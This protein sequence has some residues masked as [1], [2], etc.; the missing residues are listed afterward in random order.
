MKI[1]NGFVSNSSSSSFIIM[2]EGETSTVRDVAKIMINK[3]IE[4][5]KIGWGDWKVNVEY[6]NE[7]LKNL[8]TVDENCSVEFPSTNY[9]TWIKKI[10]DR[11]LISTCNNK[12]WDLPNQTVMSDELKEELKNIISDEDDLENFFDS[13]EFY[14]NVLFK[15]FY[16]LN[17]GIVGREAIHDWSDTN[18]DYHDKYCKKIREGVECNAHLWETKFGIKC[19]IC[20]KALFERKEKLEQLK[21][22]KE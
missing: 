1:R 15:D 22:L 5:I 19:P 18:Y 13:Y 16:S 20:D 7:W 21:K 12:D 3:L 4:D 11:I 14:L 9:D 6:K 17:F 2:A 8:E 10:G